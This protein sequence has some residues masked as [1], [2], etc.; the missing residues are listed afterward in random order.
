MCIICKDR[1]EQSKMH[2]FK[3]K[4][5]YI[6]KDDGFGR[7]YYMCVDCIEKDDKTLQ[8]AFFK[9][10]KNLNTQPTS[11]FLKEILLNGKG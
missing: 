4:S 2:K 6:M 10:C 11:K 9:I 5:S 8:K 7:S 1:I 3:I